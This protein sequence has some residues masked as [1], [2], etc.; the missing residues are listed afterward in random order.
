M[1]CTCCCI[2]DKFVHRRRLSPLFLIKFYLELLYGSGG[3]DGVSLAG[4]AVIIVNLI[5]ER[6]ADSAALWIN[7]SFLTIVSRS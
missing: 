5:L 6:R 1:W 3:D 7:S 4:W 2:L